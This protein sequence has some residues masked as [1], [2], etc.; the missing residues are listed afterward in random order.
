MISKVDWLSSLC[1]LTELIKHYKIMLSLGLT[2]F[3]LLFLV[4]KMY[5]K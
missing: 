5:L 1:L 3:L 4:D 2:L